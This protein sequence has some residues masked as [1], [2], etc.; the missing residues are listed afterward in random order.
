MKIKRSE[1]T[2][3]LFVILVVAYLIFTVIYINQRQ[4]QKAVR[5]DIKAA[6]KLLGESEAHRSSLEQQ[7]TDVKVEL[8]A[9]VALFTSDLTSTLVVDEVL[10]LGQASQ[11]KIVNTRS[12]L[13]S[14]KQVGERTFTVLPFYV[15]A[16][17]EFSQL[18]AFVD[19][20]EKETFDTILMK[21]VKIAQGEG[22][23]ALDLQFL[24]YTHAPDLEGT[25]QETT[26]GP[27]V[28]GA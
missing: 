6:E 8:D 25:P 13:A 18:M 7:L 3:V 14:D 5:A 19:R 24:I 9:D 16:E 23:F 11:V 1:L 28:D 21:T 10:E 17:G 15:R 27:G 20:L 12:Q 2:V 26:S 4:D 22:S